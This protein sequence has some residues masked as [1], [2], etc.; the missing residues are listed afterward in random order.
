MNMKRGYAEKKRGC[1]ETLLKSLGGKRKGILESINKEW[2][3]AFP[4]YSQPIEKVSDRA[5]IGGVTQSSKAKKALCDAVVKEYLGRPLDFYENI[6]SLPDLTIDNY[7]GILAAYLCFVPND[8]EAIENIIQQYEMLVQQ[9]SEG[10]NKNDG[11]KQ[12]D[13]VDGIEKMQYLSQLQEKIERAERILVEVQDTISEQRQQE[14]KL[15]KT[16]SGLE[17]QKNELERLL[18]LQKEELDTESKRKETLLQRVQELQGKVTQLEEKMRLGDEITEWKNRIDT[19]HYDV[20]SLKRQIQE[21]TEELDKI[22]QEI[23]DRA[24]TTA[25]RVERRLKEAINRDAD[26]AFDGV[27]AEKMF[28]AAAQWSKDESDKSYAA[29]TMKPKEEIPLVSKD[30]LKDYLCDMVKRYRPDYTNNDIINIFICLAQNFITVFSGEPGTGK[31]SICNI[32]AHIMGLSSF[33]EYYDNVNGVFTNRYVPISVEKGW[34]SKRDFIGYYNP[35]SQRFESANRQ[36]VD[37]LRIL[38][39][40]AGITEQ[41]KKDNKEIPT[42]YPYMVLLDEAN[43]SPMEYYW[44]DFMNI[45][46]SDTP[47]NTISLGNDIQLKIPETLRFTVTINNDHTTEILSPRL[48]DRSAIVV[49]PE[50]G[51]TPAS[52]ENFQNK[53]GVKVVSWD[54]LGD[55]FGSNVDIDKMPTEIQAVYDRIK[56]QFA[57]MKIRVSP[58]TD[59]AIQRYWSVAQKLFEVGTDAETVDTDRLALDYAVAQ[60]LLPK[61]NGSGKKYAD[62]LAELLKVFTAGGLLKSEDILTDIIQRGEESMNYYQFF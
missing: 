57:K 32:I 6:E 10:N 28:Q 61:I 26:I 1:L 47:L 41:A 38:D 19:Y 15:S 44:A 62:F 42:C 45:C 17:Q 43:L 3:D 30:E 48:I 2:K 33:E 20:W 24:S 29:L 37:G 58:R 54:V 21:K 60:K 13:L 55:V 49:L 8:V 56:N 50:V 52:D 5:I 22:N 14:R 27:I 9:E 53:V 36:L 16:L 46:D 25:D 59:R 40:E 7:S 34:M 12:E 31:T 23:E 4:Q 51:Y 18:E 11:N 39:I 35:L